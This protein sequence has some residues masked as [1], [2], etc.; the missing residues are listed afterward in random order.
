[1]TFNSPQPSKSPPRTRSDHRERP[2]VPETAVPLATAMP[3]LLST[4]SK[5][6]GRVGRPRSAVEHSRVPPLFDEL[7]FA[8]SDRPY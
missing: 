1:M 7:L 4:G 2:K 6:R 8:L 5:E 3:E